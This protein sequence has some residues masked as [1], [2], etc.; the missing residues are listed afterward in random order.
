[1]IWFAYACIWIATAAAVIFAIHATESAVPLWAMI[2]PA[3]IS[4]KKN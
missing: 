3:L 1:M 2:L 4:I